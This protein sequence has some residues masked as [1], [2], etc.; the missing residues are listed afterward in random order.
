MDLFVFVVLLC[1]TIF[2]FRR[3]K[4]V[5]YCIAI[6]DIMLR[7]L[8]FIKLNIEIPEVFIFLNKHIPTSVLGIIGHYTTGTIFTI[9]SWTY[10][11]CFVLFEYFI[12]R[13]FIKNKYK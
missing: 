9:L 1:I 10:V 11:A 4:A 2:I 8:T 12:I 7:I 13:T 6:I 3:F 5:I